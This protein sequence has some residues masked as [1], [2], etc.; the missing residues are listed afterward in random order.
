MPH[1]IVEYSDHLAID[2]PKLLS[3]L[4]NDL[5]ARDTVT[6][7]A[8]KTRAIPIEHCVIGDMDTANSIIHIALK[9]LPGR[10][11]A[12]KTQMTQGL[13]D[14]AAAHVKRPQ[15]PE[16]SITVECLTLDAESYIK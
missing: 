7:K 6:I 10:D 4:H 11:D 1:I 2:I 5:A 13:A 12:L 3:E 8:I 15:N 16:C 9:L 14:I